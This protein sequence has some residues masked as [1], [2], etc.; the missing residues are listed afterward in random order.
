MLDGYASCS[1]KIPRRLSVVYR[2]GK[3][4]RIRGYALLIGTSS[5]RDHDPCHH[6]CMSWGLAPRDVLIY[7]RWLVI[8]I[9]SIRIDS[10]IAECSFVPS[11]KSWPITLDLSESDTD[12]RQ[13]SD[14]GVDAIGTKG[15]V[16]E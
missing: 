8:Q 5:I 4:C 12:S 1:L 7:H 13:S 14:E 3:K 15:I 16:V 6:L 10:G 2:G 11:R 9:H